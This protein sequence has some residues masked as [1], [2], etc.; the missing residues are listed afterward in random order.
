MRVVLVDLVAGDLPQRR[1]NLR[2]GPG[3]WLAHVG[4][5]DEALYLHR[6]DAA[7][8]PDGFAELERIALGRVGVAQR[9]LPLLGRVWPQEIDY[10]RVDRFENQLT[11]GLELR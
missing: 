3:G 5:V 9:A 4:V 11:P 8:K 2:D 6:A 1:D 10:Q 7:Q